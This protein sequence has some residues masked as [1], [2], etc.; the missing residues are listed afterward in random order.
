MAYQN[1]HFE[2]QCF[3]YLPSYIFS[4]L[5]TKAWKLLI[6]CGLRIKPIAY[7]SGIQKGKNILAVAK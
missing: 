4:Q 7:L 1:E 3:V 5:S 2:L 6:N